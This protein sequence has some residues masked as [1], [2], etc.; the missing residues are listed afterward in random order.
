MV[1]NTFGLVFMLAVVGA[2]LTIAG[3]IGFQPPAHL[4]LDPATWTR[5]SWHDDILVRQVGL[6]VALL[7]AAGLIVRRTALGSRSIRPCPFA[8][9]SSAAARSRTRSSGSP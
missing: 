5:G 3:L 6:G 4:S 1:R 2:V 9:T 8:A 7:I